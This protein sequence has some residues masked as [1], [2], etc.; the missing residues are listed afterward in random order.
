MRKAKN[1]LN[2]ENGKA[3][4]KGLNAGAKVYK[5][6]VKPII[7]VLSKSTDFRRKN[8]LK[9]NLRHKTTIARD[10]ESGKAIIRI[11]RTKGRKMASIHANTRD[12]TD[13][14]YWFLVDRGTSKMRGANFMEQGKRLGEKRALEAAKNKY[15]EEMKK[16]M[17]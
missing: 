8:T 3:M 14:F 9:N 1:A 7:P 10:K 6:I 16:F 2:N 13:P 12:K 4:R 5:D 11:R 15:F 17:R